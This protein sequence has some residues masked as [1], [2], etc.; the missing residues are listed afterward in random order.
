MDRYPVVRRKPR[1]EPERTGSEPERQSVACGDVLLIADRPGLFMGSIRGRRIWVWRASG[2][3]AHRTFTG[4]PADPHTYAFLDPV[5]PLTAIVAVRDVTL[6][7]AIGAAIQAHDRNAAIL[8]Y[9]ADPVRERGSDDEL[10]RTVR[11][12]DVAGASVEREL[13]VLTAR[14]RVRALREFVAQSAIVPIMLHP[15]PDPDALASAHALH[16]LLA[17]RDDSMPIVTL[18]EITRPENRRMADLLN[19]EVKSVT[20]DQLRGCERLICVDGQPRMFDDAAPPRFAVIDHH[21]AE[22]GYSAD[23]FD[24]RPSVGATA[25][26]LTEYLRAESERLTG[27]KLATA[28]LYGITTDTSSLTRG[29]SPLDVESY[30]YLLDRADQ[31][32]LRKIERPAYSAAT[33]RAYGRAL[34]HVCTLDGISTAYVGELDV[35]DSHI[36]ADIADFL[37]ALEASAWAVAGAIVEGRLIITLRHLGGRPGA[38]DVARLLAHDSGSGG[39]HDTMARAVLPLDTEWKALRG[40]DANRGCELLLEKVGARILELKKQK[41]ATSAAP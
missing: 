13:A 21:P 25:S 8:R 36:L 17:T 19:I 2:R 41:G 30:T 31:P 1:R 20:L 11:W 15:D 22:E 4:D 29:V 12:R 32:L 38:G 37:L 35:D 24:I 26:I 33:A 27:P 9:G 7:A 3:G 10:V 6:R 5:Q 18:D 23:F 14:L 16:T 28:L 39:G 34:A 40:S